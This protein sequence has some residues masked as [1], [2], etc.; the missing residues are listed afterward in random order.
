MTKE[1]DLPMIDRRE[2]RM[3]YKTSSTISM[4]WVRGWMDRADFSHKGE[5]WSHSINIFHG[6]M[7]IF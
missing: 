5:G 4:D 7:K 2:N 6:T 3:K 1:T